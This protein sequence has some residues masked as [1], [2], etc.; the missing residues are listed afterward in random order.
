MAWK[1][2]KFVS[3]QLAQ[4]T[5]VGTCHLV[6][7]GAGK[8]PRETHETLWFSIASYGKRRQSVNLILGKY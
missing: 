2:N 8:T 6:S 7:L 1:Y 4:L 5:E 3:S